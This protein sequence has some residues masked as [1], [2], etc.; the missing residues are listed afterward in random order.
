MVSRQRTAVIMVVPPSN[1]YRRLTR[2]F[3]RTG[4]DQRTAGAE[5]VFPARP[6][7]I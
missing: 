4:F 5:S 7:R 3:A 2:Q 6:R 1:C